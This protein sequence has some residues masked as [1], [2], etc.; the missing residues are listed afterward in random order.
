M[1]EERRGTNRAYRPSCRLVSLRW[2]YFSWGRRHSF[3]N[4]MTLR[5]YLVIRPQIIIWAGSKY[6]LRN[7]WAEEMPSRQRPRNRGVRRE[8]N[9]EVNI[10]ES[11]I[12]HPEHTEK[13]EIALPLTQSKDKT[14]KISTLLQSYQWKNDQDQSMPVHA[15]PESRANALAWSSTHTALRPWHQPLRIK[16]YMHMSSKLWIPRICKNTSIS[17][18]SQRRRPKPLMI[19]DQ[20]NQCRSQDKG[21][22]IRSRQEPKDLWRRRR[23]RWASSPNQPKMKMDKAVPIIN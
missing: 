4:R 20:F 17:K 12:N 23:W 7:S 5:S 18:R 14:W 10:L 13:A 2:Q 22:S 16:P 1:P 8:H 21:T 6:Q 11:P 9:Q 3:V 19:S 15:P